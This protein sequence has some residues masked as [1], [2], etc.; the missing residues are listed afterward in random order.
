M[1]QTQF[2]S[3]YVDEIRDYLDSLSSRLVEMERSKEYKDDLMDEIMRLAHTCKSSSN[4]MG[5]ERLTDLFH[6]M[7]DI[8]ESVR[9]KNEKLKPKTFDLIFEAI[10]WVEFALGSVESSSKEPSEIPIINRLR[11]WK[12][13]ES[14]EG[15]QE[16]LQTML[17][18]KVAPIE[19][20]NIASIRVNAHTLDTLIDL[21]RD[22]S[23]VHMELKN[24]LGEDDKE[25]KNQL[26]G[27][28]GEVLS[29]MQEQIH[30]CRLIPVGQIVL[31]FPKL[32]RDEAR[33]YNK[34]VKFSVFSSV[35]H[36]DK[37]LAE[38]LHGPLIH[39]LRNAVDHGI[40]TPEE[41]KEIGKP[42]EGTVTLRIERME[43]SIRIIVED[44]G[45][46]I[47]IDELKRVARKNDIS[48][49]WLNT[50]NENNI[51]D[52]ISKPHFT[53]TQ[54][55]SQTAG[56]GVGL[57]AVRS[58]VESFAGTLTL[59]QEEDGKSFI[60]T[61]PAQLSVIEA[62]LIESKESLYAVPNAYVKQLLHIE[63]KNISKAAGIPFIEAEGESMPIVQLEDFLKEEP[64]IS[65][66]DSFSD[67]K[68]I[69]TILLKVQD[70]YLALAIDRL[71][72]RDT[73]MIKPR[74]TGVLNHPLISGP[75]RLPSG[76][77]IRLLGIPE[78]VRTIQNLSVSEE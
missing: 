53:T 36:I 64:S 7:E 67:D 54:E 40:G 78:L 56:R 11:E 63:K 58:A 62:L 42:E 6:A 55:V 74:A 49:K 18:K 23:Q 43:E 15:E 27:K 29:T 48:E 52:L 38:R 9:G 8:F 21:S 72:S 71:L 2:I 35:S 26:V 75:T 24:S 69:V 10:D 31:Q 30:R 5:F 32:I 20:A 4:I 13:E 22:L 73:I 28:M 77:E 65:S 60:I 34:N 51:I 47:D 14:K 57:S 3:L 59:S 50:I 70:H 46:P 19:S 41:R 37:G 16:V 25:K 12:E 39:L 66:L 33:R 45:K 61:V 76:T 1:P 44:D 68:Q 17:K